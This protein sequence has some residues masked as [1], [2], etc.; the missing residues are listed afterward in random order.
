MARAPSALRDKLHEVIF[1]ADTLGGKVFDV[2]LLV[3]ILA[4]VSTVLAESVHEV[5]RDRRVRPRRIARL[6]RTAELSFTG[7]FAVEYALRL[8]AV[9]RPLAYAL[10]FF[11]V[12][13]LLSIVP[14]F[15]ESFVPGAT[16]LRAIRVLRLLRVFRVLKL[17]G[18]L[19]EAHVL[20]VAL[21]EARRKILVFLTTV[22]VVVTLLGTLAY[23]VEDHNSRVHLHTALDL[24]GD[25]HRDA[26]SLELHLLPRPSYHRPTRLTAA[27]SSGHHGWVWSI[28]PQTILG[29]VI[30]SVIMMTGYGIIAVGAATF[31]STAASVQLEVQRGTAKPRSTNTRACLACGAE[32]HDDDAA[33]CKYCGAQLRA[34]VA[35][36][37]G[38]AN[39]SRACGKGPRFNSVSTLDDL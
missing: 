8:V 36:A 13:D 2:S 1:E 32:G 15:L 37:A 18:F 31:H 24:L 22:M 12:V 38:A 3:A 11:G 27:L 25:R 39:R 35:A 14:T 28:A 33:Y 6:R 16:H 4:S 23:M 17:V 10:S 20:W 9:Q 30:A 29:Q 34:R 19:S 7:L 26:R 5:R 21:R